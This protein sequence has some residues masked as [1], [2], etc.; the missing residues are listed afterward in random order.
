MIEFIT[1]SWNYIYIFTFQSLRFFLLNPTFKL[2]F[3]LKALID[4]EGFLELFTFDHTEAYVFGITFSR[5]MS[6]TEIKRLR[7]FLL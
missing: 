2:P 3:V 1:F 7:F 5:F 4:L 6:T